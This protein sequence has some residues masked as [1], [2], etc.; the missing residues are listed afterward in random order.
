MFDDLPKPKPDAVFPRT[1]DDMSVS[2]L[3][4]YIEELRAEIKRVEG[5]MAKKKASQDAAARVFK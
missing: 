5:D 1:L 3:A 2:E 4:D